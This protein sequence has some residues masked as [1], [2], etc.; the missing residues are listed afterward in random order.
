MEKTKMERPMTVKTNIKIFCSKLFQTK[1]PHQSVMVNN[2][3]E[4]THSPL[5]LTEKSMMA[6]NL[7]II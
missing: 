2:Q 5:L 1:I 6:N 3:T 4:R 7:R